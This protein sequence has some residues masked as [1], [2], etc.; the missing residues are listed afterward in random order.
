VHH[1]AKNTDPVTS[2]CTGSLVLGDAGRMKGDQATFQWIALA[3]SR[4]TTVSCATEPPNKAGAPRNAAPMDT[5]M[6][7]KT[8]K[9]FDAMAQQALA[10]KRAR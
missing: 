7:E 8:F 9:G 3:L 4:S 2:V 6:L 1:I 10:K 5:A